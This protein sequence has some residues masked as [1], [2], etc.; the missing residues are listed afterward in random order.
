MRLARRLRARA[1]TRGHQAGVH[2]IKAPMI[3]LSRTSPGPLCR[4]SRPA[5]ARSRRHGRFRV[6]SPTHRLRHRPRRHHAQGVRCHARVRATAAPGWRW[7]LPRHLAM[8]CHLEEALRFMFN[9][10]A[11]VVPCFLA[12]IIEYLVTTTS[13]SRASSPSRAFGVVDEIKKTTAARGCCRLPMWKHPSIQL[14]QLL[15]SLEAQSQIVRSTLLYPWHRSVFHLLWKQ[16]V[17]SM[18]TLLC[19]VEVNQYAQTCSYI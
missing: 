17:P 2:S 10:R 16:I 19:H 8:I 14:E 6:D 13:S 18:K 11:L 12:D 3:E 4:R 1:P 15:F 5:Y 9:S 7:Q